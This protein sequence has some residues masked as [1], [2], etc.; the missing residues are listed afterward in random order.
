MENIKKP[1]LEFVLTED[2]IEELGNRHEHWIFAGIKTNVKNK[3]DMVTLKRY[4]GNYTVCSGLASQ[5]Q[6]LINHDQDDEAE[7]LDNDES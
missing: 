5:M 1:N 2:L 6:F 7:P 3:D 4:S